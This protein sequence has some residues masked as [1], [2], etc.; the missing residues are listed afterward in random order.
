MNNENYTVALDFLNEDYML[1]V[2]MIE[3]IKNGTADVLCAQSDCVMVKDKGS[4]VYMLQTYDLDKADKLL[5][6]VPQNAAIVAHNPAL[7]DF[8]IDK[9]NFCCK[10]PCRQGVYLNGP[11]AFDDK[12]LEIRLMRVDEVKEAC[13]MY[14]FKEDSAITHIKKGLVYGAYVGGEAVGMVGMHI[15]GAMGLLAVKEKYRRRGYGEALES[16]II[17]DVLLK[18][19]VPYC[20]IVEGNDK[21]F[22]LQSKMGMQISK[23]QIFWLHKD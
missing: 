14:S 19:K 18:G 13:L 15:Q 2:S 20:Q 17:N 4:N 3:P 22:A 8:V 11:F 10:T 9:M 12:G 5:S 21:S 6:S 1:N 7:A 23:N 16:F